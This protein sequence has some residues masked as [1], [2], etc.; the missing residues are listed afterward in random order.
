VF[1]TFVC[2]HHLSSVLIFGSLNGSCTGSAFDVN[3][4]GR[5]KPSGTWCY[6]TG[7]IVHSVQK[8]H[9]ELFCPAS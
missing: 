3:K 4:K 6:V 5:L 8:V 1:F 9:Q 2:V 7:C